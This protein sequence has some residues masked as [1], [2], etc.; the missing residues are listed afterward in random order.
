MSGGLKGLLFGVSIP[1]LIFIIPLTLSIVFALI[2]FLYNVISSIIYTKKQE[3]LKKQEK[4]EKQEKL[5]K[6]NKEI[7]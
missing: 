5:E 3:K 4:S 7:K 1:L 2:G 6:D